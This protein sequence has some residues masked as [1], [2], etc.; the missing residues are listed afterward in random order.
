MEQERDATLHE[1]DV[2]DAALEMIAR[3]RD[4]KR[5]NSPKP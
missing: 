4:V 5:T 2:V 1:K 3:D